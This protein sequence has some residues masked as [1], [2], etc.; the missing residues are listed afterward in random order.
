MWNRR[1]C[2]GK[3]AY[4]V[5]VE[6]LTLPHPETVDRVGRTAFARD[7]IGA[8][9]NWPARPP[10]PPN[11]TVGSSAPVQGGVFMPLFMRFCHKRSKGNLEIILNISKVGKA[12]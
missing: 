5:F 9:R 7:E 12:V 4:L 1:Q 3:N 11:P 10:H 8:I 2:F 6:K